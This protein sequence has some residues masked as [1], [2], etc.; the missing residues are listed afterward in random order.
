VS[1]QPFGDIPLFREIQKLLQAG[2]GPVN[3]EI[4]RQVATAL[5]VQGGP[6]ALPGPEER[7][8]FAEGVHAAEALLAG[9][10]R[11]ALVEPMRPAVIARTDWVNIA[12]Q[13]WKWLIERA[14]RRFVDEMKKLGGDSE[15]GDAIGASLE[16][17]APLLLGIQAGTLVGNLAR[18]IVGRHDLPIV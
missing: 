12:L 6:G 18:E 11:L 14:G 17:V 13:G 4:A 9:Y 2:G 10:T 7:R 3:P 15:G 5:A 16:Q 1:Q 8:L